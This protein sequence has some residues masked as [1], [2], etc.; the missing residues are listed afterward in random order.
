MKPSDDV[1]SL[2]SRF[3]ASADS[4]REIEPD[5]HY[6]EPQLA[7]PSIAAPTPLPRS[8]AEPDSNLPLPPT[9]LATE[10]KVPLRTLLQELAQQRQAQALTTE[11]HQPPQ[12]PIVHAKVI[13][14]VSTNGGVGK[15]TL[16]SALAITLRRPDGQTIALDLDPQNALQLHLGVTSSVPGISQT[17]IG[18]DSWLSICQSGFADTKLLAY[19]AA[20]LNQRLSLEH[21]L[22]SDPAW[23]GRQL[24]KMALSERDTVIIDTPSSSTVYVNQALEIADIVV[25]VILADAASYANL[26]HVDPLLAPYLAREKPLFCTFVINQV[27]ESRQLSLDMSHVLANRL[28]ARLLGTVDQDDFIGESLAYERNPFAHLPPT[29]GCQNILDIAEALN[30]QL[31]L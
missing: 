11:H 19:G 6:V 16:A 20:E 26:T 10:Q 5:L 28:G 29:R 2:L 12:Q 7:E 8:M 31:S 23:L 25:V 27:D 18:E 24:Q 21:T 9:P 4:Y 13:A 17:I 14:V 1:A 30:Q 15:S 3:G 22:E